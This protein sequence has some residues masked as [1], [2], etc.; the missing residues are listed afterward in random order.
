MQCIFPPY[1]YTDKL[2]HMHE[3]N[4]E[5]QVLVCMGLTGS[6]LD[7]LTVLLGGCWGQLAKTGSGQRSG[8]PKSFSRAWI[9]MQHAGLTQQWEWQWW[10]HASPSGLWCVSPWWDV[11][12]RGGTRSWVSKLSIPG[13][14]TLQSISQQC[15]YLRCKQHLLLCHNND[16]DPG[17]Q[18][19]LLEQSA[20]TKVEMG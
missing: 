5:I 16:Y 15:G 17:M 7:L 19:V 2:K 12:V 3:S 9:S 18:R 13:K 10:E 4:L 11:L 8:R 1:Y 20:M 6:Y 14:P